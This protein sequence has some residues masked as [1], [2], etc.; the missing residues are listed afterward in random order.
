MDLN[1]VLRD[2]KRS[3]MGLKSPLMDQRDLID[4]NRPLMDQKRSHVDLKRPIL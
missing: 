1:R 2:L 4:L 3:N